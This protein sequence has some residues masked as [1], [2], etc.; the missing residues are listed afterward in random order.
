MN[1]VVDDN[2]RSHSFDGVAIE[3]WLAHGSRLCHRV[4]SRTSS[5]A[6]RTIALHNRMPDLFDG[7]PR[8]YHGKLNLL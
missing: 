5:S 8:L 1:A 4:C 6:N 3:I 2:F 7:S